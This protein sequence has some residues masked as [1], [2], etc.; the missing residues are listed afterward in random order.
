MNTKVVSVLAAVLAAW[1]VVTHPSESGHFVHNVGI[2]TA[3]AVD[4]LKTFATSL[5]HA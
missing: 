4:G 1:L 2:F 5:K 3:G